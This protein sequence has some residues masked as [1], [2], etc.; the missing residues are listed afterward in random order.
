MNSVLLIDDSFTLRR[1]LR[2]SFEKEGFQVFEAGTGAEGFEFVK[3]FEGKLQ[4]IIADQNMPE[5]SGMDMVEAIRKLEDQ[6]KAKVIIVLV[7]SDISIE[8]RKRAIASEVR[9][10]VYKPIKPQALVKALI[11]AL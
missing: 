11:K 6:D 7:T 3:N 2:V 5:M 9:A 10:I 1:S 8:T 4:F